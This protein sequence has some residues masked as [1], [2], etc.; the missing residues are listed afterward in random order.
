[1]IIRRAR[2]VTPFYVV[3]FPALLILSNVEKIIFI[4]LLVA[5]IAFLASWSKT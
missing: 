5:F 1:M 4:C 2:I 3:R